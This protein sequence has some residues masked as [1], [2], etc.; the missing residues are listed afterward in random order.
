MQRKNSRQKKINSLLLFIF[1][2]LLQIIYNFDDSLLEYVKCLSDSFIKIKQTDY[3]YQFSCKRIDVVDRPVSKIVF[4]K[5][6]KLASSSL[7]IDNPKENSVFIESEILWDDLKNIEFE[8]F[9]ID[10]NNKK[11]HS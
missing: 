6:E 5:S 7:I 9:K 4:E 1:L 2:L 3:V 10:I 11:I 8:V